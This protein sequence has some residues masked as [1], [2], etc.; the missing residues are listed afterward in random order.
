MNSKNSLA[1]PKLL[2]R[3]LAVFLPF[4][5]D[6]VYKMLLRSPIYPVYILCCSQLDSLFIYIFF[7]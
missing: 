5:S 1:I 2:S 3:Y 6:E 4:L 7:C